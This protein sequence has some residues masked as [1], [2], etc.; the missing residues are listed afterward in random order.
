MK[1]RLISNC[2]SVL[3]S[4][5]V[6]DGLLVLRKIENVPTGPNNKPK[7]AVVITQCGEM[8]N[9]T[10]KGEN[11]SHLGNVYIW[12]TGTQ[13]YLYKKVTRSSIEMYDKLL[14]KQL[15]TWNVI[16]GTLQLWCCGF[17]KSRLHVRG[18]KSEFRQ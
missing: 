6:I 1:F 12:S 10:N 18:R 5:K 16:K 17:I 9:D 7:I 11:P 3:F 8:W 13:R 2:Y 14:S 4:G 15:E